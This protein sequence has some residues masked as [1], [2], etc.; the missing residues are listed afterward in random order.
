MYFRAG[1][2]NQNSTQSKHYR[3]RFTGF[4]QSD[5]ANI[6]E[7]SWWNFLFREPFPLAISSLSGAQNECSR[8][9]FCGRSKTLPFAFTI[10]SNFV[11]FINYPPPRHFTRH[12]SIDS[13]WLLFVS[14]FTGRTCSLR[15]SF[16][17]YYQLK[18]SSLGKLT[19]LWEEVFF[20]VKL[21]I[22]YL[23]SPN[24]NPPPQ[25]KPITSCC[26]NYYNIY[27]LSYKLILGVSRQSKLE[28]WKW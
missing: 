25:K 10:F 13:L 4:I 17:T 8:L 14:N 3:T 11:F 1:T 26:E 9:E 15:M 16:S 22:L 6:L 21:C 27:P 5:W 2:W 23:L 28:A 18:L 24:L 20:R 19:R 7:G 12:I